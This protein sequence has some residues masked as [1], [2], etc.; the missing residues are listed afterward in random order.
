MWCNQDGWS[1]AQGRKA[2]V[3]Q[4]SCACFPG[5]VSIVMPVHSAHPVKLQSNQCIACC[6][7]VIPVPCLTTCSHVIPACTLVECTDDLAH[8]LATYLAAGAD[9]SVTT[10]L[11]MA[12]TRTVRPAS[13]RTPQRHVLIANACIPANLGA[14]VA[15][16]KAFE[17]P[18]T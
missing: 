14:P 15:A 12:V 7:C 8:A 4:P 5:C 16:C 18:G 13:R 9:K 2:T 17:L 3:Q 10:R 6:Q 1:S 11:P